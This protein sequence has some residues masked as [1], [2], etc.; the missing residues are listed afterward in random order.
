MA[1]IFYFTRTVFGSFDGYFC[2]INECSIIM[3]TRYSTLE[4]IYDAILPLTRLNKRVLREHAYALL[5]LYLSFMQVVKRMT[6]EYAVKYGFDK[7]LKE[8]HVS[9]RGR[10]QLGFYNRYH[11]LYLGTCNYTIGVINI[12][13]AMILMIPDRTKETMLHELCHFEVHGHSKR[14]YLLLDELMRREQLSRSNMPHPPLLTGHRSEVFMW[15]IKKVYD[16]YKK[17]K[18]QE[19]RAAARLAKVVK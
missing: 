4:E 3:E 2:C 5:E 18:Q 11:S 19:A 10:H 16:C 15:M 17:K 13:P 1:G 9:F 6:R 7:Q 8:V 14:F 12:N